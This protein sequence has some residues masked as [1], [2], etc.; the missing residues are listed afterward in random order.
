M[1]ELWPTAR[2]GAADT[3]EGSSLRC[4][5]IATQGLDE[6]LCYDWRSDNTG[7]PD[8]LTVAAQFATLRRAAP[9]ARV[10]SF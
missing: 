4:S 2:Y 9:T 7:P 8:S 5:C 3:L 1:T 10:L 6:A